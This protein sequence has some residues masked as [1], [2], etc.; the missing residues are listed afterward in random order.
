MMG[1]FVNAT[2]VRLLGWFMAAMIAGLNLWLLI[3]QFRTGF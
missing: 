3:V 2:W 1:E